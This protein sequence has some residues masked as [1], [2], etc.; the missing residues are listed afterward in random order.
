[1]NLVN[2]ILEGVWKEA[3][4]SRRHSLLHLPRS[5]LRL[6]AFIENRINSV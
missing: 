3:Q 5:G 2:N 6:H 1:M 4:Q